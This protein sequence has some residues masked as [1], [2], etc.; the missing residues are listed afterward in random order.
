MC[1]CVCLS[2]NWQCNITFLG[3]YKCGNPVTISSFVY[4]C[5]VS[6][7]GSLD[8]YINRRR[9]A[10]RY[11]LH[12]VIISFVR[13]FINSHTS[14]RHCSKETMTS[15]FIE[16]YMDWCDIYSID[17]DRLVQVGHGGK[18]RTKREVEQNTNR[19]DPSG[20]TRKLTRKLI[21]LNKKREQS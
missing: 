10:E 1:A 14:L 8:L 15:Y 16:N 21:N 11:R 3:E 13:L 9:T 2:S 5:S 20:H 19:R 18:R 12:A 6:R 17:Q 7:G 4:N